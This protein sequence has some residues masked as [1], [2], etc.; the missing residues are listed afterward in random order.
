MEFRNVICLYFSACIYIIYK[1][2]GINKGRIPVFSV[3]SVGIAVDR[4]IDVY[5]YFEKKGQNS[6]GPGSALFILIY[7]RANIGGVSYYNMCLLF[8]V[9]FVIQFMRKRYIGAAKP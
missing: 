9:W 4:S 3:N 6:V 1:G 7:S 5:K 8:F 2:N